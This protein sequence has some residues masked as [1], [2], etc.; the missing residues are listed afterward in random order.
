MRIRIAHKLLVVFLLVGLVPMLVGVY[1]L[2]RQLH[3]YQQSTMSALA[4]ASAEEVASRLSGKLEEIL[5][6]L[7]YAQRRLT[8]GD[9]DRAVLRWPY[10][11]FP[12]LLRLLVVDNDDRVVAV[13]QRFGYLAE[14]SRHVDL[15]HDGKAPVSFKLWNLEPQLHIQ[16]PVID[17]YSGEKTG[18]L[19]AD[20]SL[21]GM[22]EKLTSAAADERPPY[23]VAEDG[24]VVSHAD[25]NLVLNAEDMSAQPVVR[26][27]LD[28]AA[29]AQAEYLGSDGTSVLGVGMPV[30]GMPLLAV[31]EIPVERAYAL[32]RQLFKNTLVVFALAGLLL[33]SVA[34][35]LSRS[36]TRP[37]EH[38]ERGTRRV[39]LGDLNFSIESL[40]GRFP[41]ESNE[42]VARFNLMLSALKHDRESRERVEHELLRLKHYLSNIIDSMP[43][44]LVGVDAQM[45][46]THWNR[47]AERVTGTSAVAAIGSQLAAVCPQMDD[48]LEKVRRS[49]ASGRPLVD[50]KVDSKQDDQQRYLDITIYPLVTDGVEGAVIRLDDVT[51]RV[52]LEETVI[53]SEKMLTVGGLAAGMAHEIN[54]PLAGIMQNTQVIR[55]RL[56]GNMPKN[57]EAAEQCGI[58]MQALGRYLEKREIPSLLDMVTASGQRA[59]KIVTNMLSFSRKSDS[60]FLPEDMNELLDSALELAANDYDLKKRFDFR[61]IEIRRDF[62][63]TLPKVPCDK[64][65]IQQVV[66]NILKN[67]A[68]AMAQHPGPE[69]SPCFELRTRRDGN[70]VCMEIEDNGPG[71]EAAVRKRIFEPFFTTKE[72]GVGTGLGL[73][74]SYFIIRENHRGSLEVRSQPG[75]GACFIVKLPL[76]SAGSEPG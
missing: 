50:S 10:D 72:I 30:P 59:A 69:G 19:H 24:R 7:S 3:G 41:D 27:L 12:E 22:F 57:R 32:S 37:L 26:A 52:R 33:I 28:G 51:E 75:R 44:V 17:L 40:P 47:E 18:V 49:I 56:T 70:H 35:L 13:L 11:Q 53:Q 34:V 2:S 42:L 15:G 76:D 23:V 61:S 58:S 31:K 39:E 48:E 46:V 8:I 25:I 74:V 64:G 43:S 4:H 36:I 63:P 5:G 29:F 1:F 55:N 71:I 54:N 9:R 21:K 6:A 45:R 16:I 14:G 73:S 66:L 62:D 38:M 68:Q 67:G 60:G 65:K 20:L